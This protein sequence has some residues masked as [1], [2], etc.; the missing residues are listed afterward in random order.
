VHQL[1]LDIEHYLDEA[2]NT[3]AEW[4]HRYLAFTDYD[5]QILE[6]CCLSVIMEW[7]IAECRQHREGVWCWHGEQWAQWIIIFTQYSMDSH[8]VSGPPTVLLSAMCCQQL[9][10]DSTCV[11][12]C[13]D[14]QLRPVC[15]SECLYVCLCYCQVSADHA[16]VSAIVFILVRACPPDD[17]LPRSV[18]V[19]DSRTVLSVSWLS[20]M[21]RHIHSW[22]FVS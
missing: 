16:E 5:L 14:W 6:V 18:S 10:V 21:T 20:W 3:T 19:T 7:L 2:I 1:S 17:S 15:V 11:N 9:T 13:Y 22:S 12:V 4:G 8:S